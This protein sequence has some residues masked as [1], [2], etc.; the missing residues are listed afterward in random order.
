MERSPALYA[1]RWD[2]IDE[3]LVIIATASPHPNCE[4][5]QPVERHHR[6]MPDIRSLDDTRPGVNDEGQ[7]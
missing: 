5:R 1:P 3:L 4:L 6:M 2:Q 7:K